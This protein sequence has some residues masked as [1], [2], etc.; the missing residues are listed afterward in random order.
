MMKPETQQELMRRY[1][2]GDLPES[3]T[4]ELELQVLRDDERF[5]EMWEV[6]NG[7]VD[8]YVRGRLSADEHERFERH[9]QASPIHRQRVAVARNLVREA[10][11]S[12]VPAAPI[13]EKASWTAGLN[14]KLGFSVW[15]WRSALATA[16]VLLAVASFWLLLD[17]SRLR[18]G[19]D[20][21]LAERQSQADREQALSQQLA[22][23][24]ADAQKLQTELEKLRAERGR[25]S[26][27]PHG[28]TSVQSNAAKPRAIYSLLLSPILTRSS[29]NT[30][31]A[32]LPPETDI[33]RL[34]MKVDQANAR[35]FHI[36]VRTVEGRQVWKQQVRS[37]GGR[38]RTAVVSA[39][40][41]AEKLPAG[42]YILTLS[43]T[44]SEGTSEEVNRY[45]FKVLRR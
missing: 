2:L 4:N 7:L 19:Q 5:E 41:P 15:S 44:D 28:S 40:I 16:M 42:D 14:Q 29:E 12:G 9:Y 36:T 21:L 27:L 34:Q 24:R 38:T 13:S 18:S 20:K 37:P 6:E 26:Q 35:G 8:G 39:Q 17:R 22:E 30:Q 23:A 45:F 43:A 10:D 33:L 25:E 31:T 1:L 3:D 32:T 11:E